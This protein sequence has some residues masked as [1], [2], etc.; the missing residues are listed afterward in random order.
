MK[1]RLLFVYLHPSPFVLDD[2]ALLEA[3]YEVRP[4]HFDVRQ[5]RAPGGMLRMIRAQRAWLQRELPGAALVLGWFVD[6]HM[7]LP[8]RMAR[9][10]GI[11]VAAVL[12]GF[13]CRCLTDLKDGVFCS[14]WRAP[15]A[16]YVYRNASL[17]FPVAASLMEMPATPWTGNRPQGVRAWVPGLNTPFRVIPTGYDP[18]QWPFGLPER[19]GIVRTVAFIDSERVL[20]LKGIDLL[21][22]AAAHLPEV[23]FEVVGVTSEM[24]RIVRERYTPPPNVRLREPVPRTALPAI[25]GET[26]VYAQLSRAEGLPN[27]LCEA[28]LCGCIPVGSPVFGI[29]E[30]IGDAG[31]IVE[32]PEVEAVV[33]AIGKALQCNA[34]WRMRARSR[35]LQLFPKTRRAHELWEALEG[36]RQPGHGRRETDR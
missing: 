19:P 20:R 14:R 30:A 9:R 6:Y 18:E 17:L 29:R 35:I 16:R 22:A 24:Q 27:A 31:F 4:F 8:V 7:V 23:Q 28:M 1:P 3:H 13:D 33:A 25:Y 10:R 2:L 36:L 26:S 5:V 12:G 21:L 15:L 34:A 11:P 32:R